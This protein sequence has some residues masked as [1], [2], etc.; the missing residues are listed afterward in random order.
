MLAFL[1][2]YSTMQG[3]SSKVSSAPFCFHNTEAKGMGVN[4][5]Q[6][7]LEE[8]PIGRFDYFGNPIRNPSTLWHNRRITE[9]QIPRESSKQERLLRETRLAEEYKALYHAN[10]NPKRKQRRKNPVSIKSQVKGLAMGVDAMD[11]VGAGVGL[12]A[13]TILPGKIVADASSTS[14]KLMRLGASAAIALATGFVAQKV[15]KDSSLAKSAILGGMAGT[16]VTAL[17]MFA[18]TLIP[19][20]SGSGARMLSAG[21]PAAAFPVSPAPQRESET[22]SLIQP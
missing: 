11:I 10:E 5:M 16:V 19:G 1:T 6:V 13:T 3:A 15:M 7:Y 9:L 2:I 18:P 21:R 4:D 14:G 17:T 12:V 8:N 20:I 22:V